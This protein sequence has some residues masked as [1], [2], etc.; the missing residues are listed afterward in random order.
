MVISATGS[1]II[2]RLE[3]GSVY[4]S[5]KT[6][7]AIQFKQKKGTNRGTLRQQP[8]CMLG[9]GVLEMATGQ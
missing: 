2:E 3:L 8:I 7:P 4:S 6:N 9:I 5:I 1:E